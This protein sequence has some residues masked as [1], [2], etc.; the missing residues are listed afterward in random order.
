MGIKFSSSNCQ[1]KQESTDGNLVTNR[2]I[3]STV[4][5]VQQQQQQQQTKSRP[6]TSISSNNNKKYENYCGATNPFIIFFLRLR[7]KKSHIPVTTIARI[8]GKRWSQMN[9]NQRQK[10]ID[11]ANDEKKRRQKIKKKR[12]HQVINS[13]MLR[14]KK[15]TMYKKK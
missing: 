2:K 8:A 3:K 9:A 11:L 1:R 12:L 5:V 13:K 7:S 4:A 14:S 6:S 15:K 10:Y